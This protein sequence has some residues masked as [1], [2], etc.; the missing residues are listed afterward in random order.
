MRLA[1]PLGGLVFF[2]FAIGS[3]KDSV[4]LAFIAS[5]ILAKYFLAG[6]HPLPAVAIHALLSLAA[7]ILLVK[8]GRFKWP[9]TEGK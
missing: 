7:L 5:A 9:A 3:V 1:I 2:I 8:W 4:V 6:S